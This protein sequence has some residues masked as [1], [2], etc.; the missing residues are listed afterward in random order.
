MNGS[1]Y[2]LVAVY[3]YRAIIVEIVIAWYY[4]MRVKVRG[5]IVA[6]PEKRE[7]DLHV[8]VYLL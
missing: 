8:L 3:R 7:I 2:V 1:F 4:P 5:A 6:E